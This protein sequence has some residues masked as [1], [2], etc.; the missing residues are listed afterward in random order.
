MKR[1]PRLYL[2][3]VALVCALLILIVSAIPLFSRSTDAQLLG[4]VF[5]AF[6]SGAMLSNLIQDLWKANRK[7]D[8]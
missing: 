6:G 7:G 3:F 5:G 2:K 4:L 8:N 1:R